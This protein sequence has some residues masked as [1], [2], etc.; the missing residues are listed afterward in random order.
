MSQLLETVH[1]S[2][3]D[4]IQHH[5]LEL[6]HESFPN[7]VI[8]WV[9]GFSDETL[10][11]ENGEMV[12]FE[13]MPFGVSLPD[14]SIRGNQDL[15]FQLDNITGDALKYVR[16]VLDSDEPLPVIYRVYLESN[17]AAPAETAIEMTANSFNAD[18]RS[19]TVIADFHDFVNKLWPVLRYTTTNTPGLKYI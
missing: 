7:G 4:E 17:T 19:V 1:A 6:P 8:R 14:K 12:L 5:T 9:Q 10:G 15:Q 13:Q 11:L 2:V 18:M 3:T 16:A